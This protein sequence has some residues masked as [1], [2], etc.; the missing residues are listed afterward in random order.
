MCVCE[1]VCVRRW[2]QMASPAAAVKLRLVAALPVLFCHEETFFESSEE[3]EAEEEEGS[4]TSL[5]LLCV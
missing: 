5:V 3:E 4:T 1:H 2:Q